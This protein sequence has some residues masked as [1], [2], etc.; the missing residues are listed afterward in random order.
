VVVAEHPSATV[1]FASVAANVASQLHDRGWPVRYLGLGPR[2]SDT[3]RWPF[4]VEATPECADAGDRLGELAP[5]CPLVLFFGRVPHLLDL[6]GRAVEIGCR[7]RIDVTYYVAVEYAPAPDALRAVEAV[8]DRLVPATRFAAVAL[9]GSAVRPIPHGVDTDRFRPLP[10]DRRAAV[11]RELGVRPDELLVAYFGRN[12]AHK[13]PDLALRAFAHLATGAH[14]RC[15]GCGH[16]TVAELDPAGAWRA[17]DRCRRCARSALVP[18]EPR[19]DVR[20]L[21]H[22]ELLGERDRR[23]SGGFDLE[24]LARRFGVA[25]RVLWDR[26]LAVGRGIPAARLAERMA[27]ADVHLLLH[28]GAGWELTVLETAACGVA[29]VVTDY[30]GPGEYAGPFSML[31]PAVS[32]VVQPFGVEAIAD[33]DAAVSALVALAEEPARRAELAAA[34]PAVAAA[35]RWRDIGDRW[36]ALLTEVAA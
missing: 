36:D 20:L 3:T 9:G 5:A 10:T 30:A 27:A 19:H 24:R 23:R 33:L 26:T 22:T 13:R 25:D 14:H 31:V 6:L 2:G 7:Q 28:Q 29:N 16:R 32:G 34:G 1:G 15:T 18:A 4:P 12:S 8:V 21:A 11:R 35:H 17:P